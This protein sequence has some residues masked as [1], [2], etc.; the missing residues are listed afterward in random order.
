MVIIIYKVIILQNKKKQGQGTG[1]FT[2]MTSLGVKKLEH[3][4]SMNSEREYC[5]KI[6]IHM[7]EKCYI[8]IKLSFSPPSPC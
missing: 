2:I 5:K 8:L 1:K 6:H 7:W 3:N 4:Y